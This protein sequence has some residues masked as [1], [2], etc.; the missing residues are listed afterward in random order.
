M[1]DK[2]PCDLC[3]SSDFK[4]FHDLRQSRFIPG[5]IVRCESCGLVFR[6]VS[7]SR[8][9]LSAYYE[10]EEY[11][12]SSYLKQHQKDYEL[13]LPKRELEVYQK[14]LSLLEGL[15]PEKGKLLDGGCARGVLLNIARKRGWDVM[16][17]E[18]SP[19]MAQFARDNF[20]L[21][22]ITSTIEEA[23][24]PEESFDAVVLW[25]VIEHPL[26]PRAMIRKTHT[27][28]KPGGIL[29][30]FTQNNDSFLVRLGELFGKIGLTSFLYHLYDNYHLFFFTGRT[31]NGYFEKCGFHPLKTHFFPADVSKRAGDISRLRSL[32]LL[33]IRVAN[34]IAALIHKQYRIAVF[35]QKIKERE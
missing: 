23:S 27:L 30:L 5:P 17:V 11:G 4:V 33:G 1:N 7:F 15:K 29:V 25:D 9:E 18:V 31:L 24:L 22:V 10:T 12:N 19:S 32:I 3:G 2:P 35:G 34:M 16:G 6:L 14:V 13:L 21:Q 28:L 20:G 8:A 26:S